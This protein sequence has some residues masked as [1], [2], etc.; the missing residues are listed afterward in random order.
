M[1]WFD[2]VTGTILV[3]GCV[4]GIAYYAWGCWQERRLNRY[5]AG[6]ITMLAGF[7]TVFLPPRVYGIGDDF[8][9]WIGAVLIFSG[10]AQAAWFK[11][12]E[13]TRET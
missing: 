11:R 6:Q 5:Y 12:R 4:A 2:A 13:T 9:F 7:L 3:V 10:L 8:T 1:D